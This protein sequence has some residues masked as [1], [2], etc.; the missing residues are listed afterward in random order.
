MAPPDSL[1]F[2]SFA[3]FGLPPDR[4]LTGNQRPPT[5]RGMFTD[6]YLALREGSCGRT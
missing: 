1:C 5:N 2:A 3:E 6:P 4:Q